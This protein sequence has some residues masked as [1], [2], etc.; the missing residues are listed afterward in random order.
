MSDWWL[1]AL[2]GCLCMIACFVHACMYV[3]MY[4]LLLRLKLH[5]SSLLLGSS[6]SI[7]QLLPLSPTP[8]LH[9][10]STS[11]L[12][13]SIPLPPPFDSSVVPQPSHQLLL[14]SSQAP[15][16]ISSISQL[17]LHYQQASLPCPCYLVE[18]VGFVAP[19]D[20]HGMCSWTIGLDARR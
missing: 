4:V 13:L 18:L 1:Y 15:L 10:S 12:V 19:V 8:C 7:P 14:S 2:D 5:R 6:F 3:C 17:M 16:L 11:L 20:T 9:P